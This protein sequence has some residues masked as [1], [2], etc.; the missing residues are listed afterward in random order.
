MRKISNSKVQNHKTKMTGRQAAVAVLNNFKP[1]A[2][3]VGR[4]LENVCKHTDERAVA[5]E[6]ILGLL[7]NLLL[8][9]TIIEKCA[10]VRSERGE[11]RLGNIIRV[12]VYELVFM[13]TQAE[14]AI[15]NEAVGQARDA[16]G[17]KRAGFVN[18][19]LRS[20]QRGIASRLTKMEQAN[21]RRVVPHDEHSGCLFNI[22][23]L[24]APANQVEY[25]SVLFSLP[26]WLVI[27]WVSN[28][29]FEQAKEICG[30][31]NRKAAIYLRPNTLKISAG[32]LESK[33][34]ENGIDAAMV[35]EAGM[36][37]VEHSG[38]VAKLPGFEEGLFVVQDITASLAVKAL[39]P[40]A[41]Q[42]VLD[43]CAAP[44]TKT[45][46]LAELMGDKGQI[47]ATDI[48]EARLEKIRENRDR[49]GMSCIDIVKYGQLTDYAKDGFDAI[50]IDAPCSNT[51][52]LGKRPEARYRITAKAIE[53]ISNTQYEILDKSAGYLKAGG[54]IC[55]STC[56]IEPEENDRIVNLFLK[57][58][59]GFELLD[60]K[61]T[62]PSSSHD[63]GYYAVL[64]LE[65]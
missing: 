44:G 33:L 20:V 9:D 21:Q 12:G 42:R 40:M 14:Y 3:N 61:L 51:G 8:I 35:N 19:I 58:N 64:A 60:S 36:V 5:P 17:Q 47:V 26:D 46:Q 31:C 62:L 59:K 34:K 30:G 13:P 39:G 38:D 65:K 54:K 48:E 15:L 27:R 56:S 24:P 49:L 37:R 1:Q 4:S 45:T 22:D 53:Q 23:I 52:V 28:F 43:I 16:V 11:K 55:Y 32:E 18:A 57:V 2:G 25:L 10:N 50:L 41:G 6:I 7:R 63:G 29:G